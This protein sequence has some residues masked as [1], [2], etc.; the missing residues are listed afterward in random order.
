MDC[1][2]DRARCKDLPIAESDRLFFLGQGG[3]PNKAAAFCAECPVINECRS[4]AILYDERGIWAGLT[5]QQRD[6]LAADLKP[7]LQ[8][9]AR[10]EGRLREYYRPSALPGFSRED[11]MG[12]QYCGDTHDGNCQNTL[13][14]QHNWL[15]STD[16]IDD[17]LPPEIL[18]EIQDTERL[19]PPHDGLR[20]T[21]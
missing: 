19:N 14:P 11:Y 6:Y 4:D 10:R 7:I 5:E 2:Q 9:E 20:L 16:D 15:Q 3:S 13:P 18:R 12:C 8:R 17:T 1:W 21:G